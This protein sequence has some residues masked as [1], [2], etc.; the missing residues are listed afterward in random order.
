MAEHLKVKD[1]IVLKWNLTKD[2]LAN[3]TTKL[4]SLDWTKHWRVTV[5]EAK[6]N[7]SLEQ[8]LRLWELYTSVSNHLGIEKDKIHELM[9][10]KFLRYQDLIAGFPVEL[11]KS[12]TKLTTAE[13]TEYQHQVEIWAQTMGWEWDL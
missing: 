12:T 1:M 13:M 5:V 2:N 10:Y 9:G 3:L 11:V 8:N 4:R 6:A 7:R